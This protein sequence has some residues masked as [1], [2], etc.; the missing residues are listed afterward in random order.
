MTNWCQDT[1]HGGDSLV[2]DEGRVIEEVMDHL[3]VDADQAY[4]TSRAVGND[5]QELCEELAGLQRDWDNLSR[6]WSGVAS[7]AYSAIWSEWLEGAT[8]LV[9]ALAESSHNLGVSAV[10]YSEQDA[11]SAAALRST[12]IDMGI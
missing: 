10:S 5:A 11:G 3:R 1:A 9:D 6:G 4:N 7:S 2:Y 12:P 8:T